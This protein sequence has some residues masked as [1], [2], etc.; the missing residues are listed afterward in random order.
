MGPAWTPIAASIIESPWLDR[1]WDCQTTPARR[2]LLFPYRQKTETKAMNPKALPRCS[3][4]HGL[5]AVRH[6][7]GQGDAAIGLD[8]RTDF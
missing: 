5:V 6:H 7:K 1:L 4:C 2:K 8:H 3:A